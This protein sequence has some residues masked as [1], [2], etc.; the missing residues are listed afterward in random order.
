M[1]ARRLILEV[2]SSTESKAAASRGRPIPEAG[3]EVNMMR[4]KEAPVDKEL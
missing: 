3:A 2:D 4:E 1:K